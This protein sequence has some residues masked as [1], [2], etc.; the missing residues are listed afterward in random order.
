MQSESPSSRPLHH[1]FVDLDNLKASK[2]RPK[3]EKTLPTFARSS[4]GKTASDEASV[5][6]VAE[7][8]E[9]GHVVIDS[10]GIVT[11]HLGSE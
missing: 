4:L 11:Y 10:K 8:R 9:A 5:S 2:D 7:L 1:V 6:V 3:K